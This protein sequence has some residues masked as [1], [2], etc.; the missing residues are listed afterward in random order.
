MPSGLLLS[1]LL[2]RRGPCGVWC[3]LWPKSTWV[4]HLLLVG[5]HAMIPPSALSPRRPQLSLA[6]VSCCWCIS[7]LRRLAGSHLG[8][9]TVAFA[10]GL[11]PHYRINYF[12][13]S[14]LSTCLRARLQQCSRSS[15]NS[16][17]AAATARIPVRLGVVLLNLVAWP[18]RLGYPR[19]FRHSLQEWTCFLVVTAPVRG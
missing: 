18:D 11:L 13:L 19:A 4:V 15:P 5:V 7:S 9:H 12:A 8:S 1:A 17:P 14:G 10:G 2:P 16:S 3:R 6:S